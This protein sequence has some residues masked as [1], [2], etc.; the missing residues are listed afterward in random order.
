MFKPLVIAAIAAISLGGATAAA[1]PGTG[2]DPEP[3]GPD[4]C[5]VVSGY[6]VGDSAPVVAVINCVP[7]GMTIE[8]PYTSLPATL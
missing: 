5:A 3:I 6:E 1:S 8:Q 2:I 7:D 4:D